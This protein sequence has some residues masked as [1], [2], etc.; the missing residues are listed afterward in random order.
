MSLDFS[1]HIDGT[2]QST[3]ASR[4]SRTGG[5]YINGRWVEG[6][7][8]VTSHTVTIQPASDRE[9]DFLQ[10]AGERIKDARRIYVND[11][12]TYSLAETWTFTGV[13][14][15]Y[16]AIS[17]DARPWRTYTKIIASRIDDAS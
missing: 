10:S 8:T 16:K 2:F 11:N 3:P 17:V 12:A 13:D 5:E 14:G 1:G 15:I 9:I 6:T 4:T 7:P